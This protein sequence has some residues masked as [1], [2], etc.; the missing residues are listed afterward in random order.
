MQGNA[1]LRSAR[2]RS[3]NLNKNEAKEAN[4]TVMVKGNVVKNKKNKIKN[5]TATVLTQQSSAASIAS[6]DI[7]PDLNSYPQVVGAATRS[8]QLE[9]NYA[10][11]ASAHPKATLTQA[12]SVKKTRTKAKESNLKT[13]NLPKSV[14][15]FAGVKVEK[16][17]KPVRLPASA[18][19]SAP[20]SAQ[21]LPKFSSPAKL[22]LK[23]RVSVVSGANL[24]TYLRALEAK[25]EN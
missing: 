24:K 22:K 6:I 25:V 20:T 9:Q 5:K 4:L 1:P 10:P 16:A 3:P 8:Q 11:Q 21:H 13:P 15:K 7:N 14:F 17:S 2:L 18:P 12:N 19:A 23:R